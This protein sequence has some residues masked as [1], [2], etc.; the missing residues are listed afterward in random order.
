MKELDEK[1]GFFKSISLWWKFEGRYYY[2][3][4][5]NG[6][7][8]LCKWFPTIW[9][10]RDWDHS[11]IFDILIQKLKNQ[12]N[13]IGKR[14]YHTRAKRDAEVMMTCVRLLEKVKVEEYGIEYLDYEVSDW[15]FVPC[16]DNPGYSTL[17]VD[18]I[19]ENFDDYFKKYPRQYKRVM[20]GEVSRFNRPV[21]KDKHSIAMEIAHENHERARRLLFKLLEQNIEKWWD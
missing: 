13:Y 8:N 7:K 19:S 10:D 5:I 16:K 3:D 1:P 14:D 18:R 11:F 4:F 21:N 20:N 17:E 2:K 9:K 15:N 6:V 12:S